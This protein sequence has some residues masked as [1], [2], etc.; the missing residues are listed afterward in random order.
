MVR[1]ALFAAL[2]GLCAWISIPTAPIAFTLQTFA[3]FLTLGVLGGK[4]GSFSILIYL[5]LGTVGVPVFSGFQGGP[6]VLLGA[7]GGYIWGFLAAGLVYWAFEKLCKPLGF[8]TGILCCYLCGCLWYSVYA[9]S[10]GFGGAVMQCVIPYLIP[11]AVKL[12]L[13]YVLSRRLRKHMK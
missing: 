10:A 6:G 2:T 11:D 13:A 3:V 7:T 8:V 4:W 9:G 12:T 1:S 5:L